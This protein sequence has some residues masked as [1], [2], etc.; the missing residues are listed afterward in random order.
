[1]NKKSKNRD[2]CWTYGFNS[3]ILI[4]VKVDTKKE[5]QAVPI[6][7]KIEAKLKAETQKQNVCAYARVS[8]EKDEAQESLANQIVGYTTLIKANKS[9]NFCGVYADEDATGTKDNRENFQKMIAQCR[10]GEIDAIITKNISRFARNTVL[11]LEYVRELKDLNID[12]FFEA[13][14]VH[15]LTAEGEILLSIIASYAQDQSRVASE[16]QNFCVARKFEKGDVIGRTLGYD[17]V[18][19]RL[20]INPD[21]AEIVRE[22]FKLYLQGDGMTK[23]GRAVGL[24]G[25]QV[26]YALK[27]ERYTGDLL[28]QKSYTPDHISKKAIRNDGTK[29]QWLHENHHDAI[30]SRAD[31]AKVQEILKAKAERYKSNKAPP[32]PLKSLIKC[33][34]CGA[35]FGYRTS[36][37]HSH[38]RCGR[39]SSGLC[40]NGAIRDAVLQ[41]AINGVEFSTITIKPKEIITDT[42]QI[43]SW[44]NP[45]RN[46]AWT[47]EKREKAR[48]T[49][50]MRSEKNGQSN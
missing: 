2:Y 12:I 36:G 34:M 13:E 42:G 20:I 38:W 50:K 35:D 33:G 47:K 14:K 31:F 5:Q 6:V 11:L 9:W 17:T 3:G 10:A 39:I 15:T 1:V 19:C 24:A 25:N 29:D 26:L 28:C 44:S 48:Q 18:D 21:E 40:K 45:P 22:I 49:T 4:I 30:I 32:Q 46:S 27:N 41:K 43:I 16:N 8:T 37:S 7:T 23:I